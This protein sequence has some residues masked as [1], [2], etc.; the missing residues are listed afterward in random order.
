MHRI[1]RTWA[2]LPALAVAL[3]AA[4][5]TSR[6]AETD[7]S[8]EI[9]GEVTSAVRVTDVSLG[10]AIGTDK[11]VTN[12]TD[13]FRAGDTIY[14]SIVTEGSAREARLTARWTY[15]DGQVVDE[16]SQT[17]AP[18]GTTVTEFHVTRPSGWPAGNYTLRVL[19]DGREVESEEFK[20]QG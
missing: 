19:L 2:I 9:G 17:I 16:S 15:Q 3:T 10:R 7:T 18:S 6:D 12:Q 20:V 11:R 5:C 1:T 8:A 13:D 4:A 14:V